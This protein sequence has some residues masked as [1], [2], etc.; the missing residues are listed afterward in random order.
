MSDSDG[1]CAFPTPNSIEESMAD[2]LSGLGLMLIS[3]SIYLMA[4]PAL[5]SYLATLPVFSTRNT[6]RYRRSLA[7]SMD[8]PRYEMLVAVINNMHRLPEHFRR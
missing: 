2:P 7:D 8:N 6:R 1:P 5:V 4:L 3:A